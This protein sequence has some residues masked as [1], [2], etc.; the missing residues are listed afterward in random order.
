MRWY[1]GADKK[2]WPVGLAVFVIAGIDF[3]V[4]GLGPYS[5]LTAFAFGTA[6]FNIYAGIRRR[7]AR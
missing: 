1:D 4:A 6:G 7:R 3:L 5:L 2:A